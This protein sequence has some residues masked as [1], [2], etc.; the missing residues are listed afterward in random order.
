MPTPLS[1]L[2]PPER[3]DCMFR[4]LSSRKKITLTTA[5]DV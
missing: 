5:I 3:Y 4:P 1:L 2:H